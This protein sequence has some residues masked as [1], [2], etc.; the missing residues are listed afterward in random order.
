MRVLPRFGGIN[1]SKL[2]VRSLLAVKRKTGEHHRNSMQTHKELL[3]DEW[4]R[5]YGD[6][7]FDHVV[8]FS[9]YAPFWIKFLASHGSGSF[10]IWL[11]NDIQAEIENAGRSAHLRASLEGVVSLFDTA[12][13]LVSVS[14]PLAEVNA[15]RLSGAAPRRE[16][17]LRPQHHQLPA[18]ARTWPT[19]CRRGVEPQL[20][21]TRRP[22]RRGG[23]G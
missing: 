11:H 9:G 6:S 22:A 10:S 17:H 13:H 3:R 21:S 15:K 2:Q 14:E 12:D 19:A 23:R 18:R 7:Q 4:L 8:D 20:P 1:G 5:C 16:V